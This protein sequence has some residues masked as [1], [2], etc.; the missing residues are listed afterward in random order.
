MNIEL[1]GDNVIMS[2]EYELSNLLSKFPKNTLY[3]YLKDYLDTEDILGVVSDYNILNHIWGNNFSI[4]DICKFFKDR[5]ETIYIQDLLEY[6]ESMAEVS[7]KLKFQL[8]CDILNLN[9]LATKQDIIN[10]IKNLLI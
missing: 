6:T 8:I 7:N 5:G 3:Q 2:S 10:E 1:K 9:H 4:G